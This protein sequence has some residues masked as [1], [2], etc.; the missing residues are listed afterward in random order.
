LFADQKRRGPNAALSR[1]ATGSR[2]TSE[3]SGSTTIIRA[4]N[5]AVASAIMTIG[6]G[7]RGENVLAARTMATAAAVA[8]A[9]TSEKPADMASEVIGVLGRRVPNMTTGKR[10]V[11]LNAEMPTSWKLRPRLQWI[12]QANNLGRISTSHRN[13]RRR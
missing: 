8:E 10:S 7:G 6:T 11:A 13:R 2:A 5:G 12:E 9:D 1:A 4:G 3:V